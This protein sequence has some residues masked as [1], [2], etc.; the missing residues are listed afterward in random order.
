M[1]NPEIVDF[2]SL[3]RSVQERFVATTEGGAAPLPLAVRALWGETRVFTWVALGSLGVLAAVGAL[4]WGFGDLDNRYALAPSWFIA[5]YAACFSVSAFGFL[6]AAVRY[7]SARA[8]PYRPAVYLFPVGVID[9]RTPRFLVYRLAEPS[10]ARVDRARR[11]LYLQ[12]D[13]AEFEFPSSDAAHAEQAL[14]AVIELR[15][16]LASAGAD[17]SARE[18]ALFDPLLDNGFKN[19]FA[20]PESLRRSVPGWI[21]IW[22]LLA[23]V[24]GVLLGG[25]AFLIRNHLSEARLYASARAADSSY[26]YRA[27]LARGGQNPDVASLLLPRTELRDAVKQDQVSAIEGFAAAHPSTGIQPEVDDALQRALLRELAQAEAAGTLRALKEFAQKY[28]RYPYLASSIDRAINL[29][30]SATLARLK[31]ALSPAQSRLL[32]FMER[33]LRYTAKHGP[34]AAVRF[35]RKPTETLENTEK[36]LR[37]SPYYSGESSLPGQSFGAAQ[38]SAREAAAAEV[39]SAAL[40]EHFPPDLLHAQPAPTLDVEAETKPSVPTILINYHSELSGA[41]TSRRPRMVLSGIG[42]LCK[43]SFEI[44]GDS[45]PLL[46]KHAVWR[47]PDLRT[48]TDASTPAA[49]YE[50]MATEA[51]RRFTKKYLATLFVEH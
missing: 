49:I 37:L 17:S 33:L 39:I 12:I 23:L 44:P 38:A 36:A 2:W 21:K 8:V 3:P 28:A 6:K 50:A 45:E 10:Q 41:F 18:Q 47:A 25:A 31:P 11:S 30:V 16:R 29:R 15:D 9:A 43:V 5:V 46:F 7:V 22:P 19:P 32:P 48:I 4:R 14:S 24:F 27:Y 20:P 1:N 26:V 40:N 13:G 51:F 42:I 34:E 35:Q